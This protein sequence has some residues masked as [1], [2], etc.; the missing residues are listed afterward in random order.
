MAEQTEKVAK[1]L[2]DNVYC[3]IC[4]EPLNNNGYCDFCDRYYT[5]YNV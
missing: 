3:D 4:G 1:E 2:L 5:E